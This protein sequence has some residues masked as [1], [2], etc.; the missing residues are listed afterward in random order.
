[1]VPA[2]RGGDLRR[3]F[4]CLLGSRPCN[5]RVPQTGIIAGLATPVSTMRRAQRATES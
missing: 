3:R 2:P 5:A 4:G 1:M